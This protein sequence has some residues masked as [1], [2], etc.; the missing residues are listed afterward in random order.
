MSYKP[1]R[2]RQFQRGRRPG[3]LKAI[4]H[5]LETLLLVSIVLVAAV[6][7]L[8]WWGAGVL[9]PAQKM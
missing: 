8:F 4:W 5:L 7:T 3:W 6:G 9:W 2:M 1:M